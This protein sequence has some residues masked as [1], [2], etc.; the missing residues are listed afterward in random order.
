MRALPVA[1]RRQLRRHRRQHLRAMCWLRFRSEDRCH[2][3]VI[4][5]HPVNQSGR[6][7]MPARPRWPGNASWSQL[8]S[9]NLQRPRG[10]AHV[11]TFSNTILN[12]KD[13]DEGVEANTTPH[14]HDQLLVA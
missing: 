5:L 13:L 12:N 8:A 1:A 4:S 6:H 14:L 7:S 10:F 3:A 2:G 9:H 11:R